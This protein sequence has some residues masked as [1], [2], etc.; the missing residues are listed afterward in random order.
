[1]T[2]K[3]KLIRDFR[4]NSAKNKSYRDLVKLTGYLDLKI[5]QGQ[6]SRFKVFDDKNRKLLELHKKSEDQ[7][8][9]EYEIKYIREMLDKL[10]V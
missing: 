2:K 6:G 5:Q 9:R 7:N 10:E 1:M 8:F 3:D 4:S